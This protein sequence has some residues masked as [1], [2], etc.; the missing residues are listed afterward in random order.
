MKTEPYPIFFMV[1]GAHNP[2]NEKSFC[3]FSLHWIFLAKTQNERKRFHFF[4]PN[5]GHLFAYLME[6]PPEECPY[7]TVIE[8]RLFYVCKKP[9]M[10]EAKFLRNFAPLQR[11]RFP[12]LRPFSDSH[13]FESWHKRNLQKTL[14]STK[15]HIV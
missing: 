11:K 10:T 8:A 1:S 4:I 3:P 7:F 5:T 6:T 13:T 14:V 9:K 15:H 2:T 12:P